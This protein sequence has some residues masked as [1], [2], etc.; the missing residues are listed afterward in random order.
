MYPKTSVVVNAAYFR[1]HL[2]GGA[3][4][5][6]LELMHHLR[7][8]EELQISVLA[9][10]QAVEAFRDTTGVDVISVNRTNYR[11]ANRLWIEQV[12]VPRALGLAMP[13]VVHTLGGMMPIRSS[14]WAN[15]FTCHDLQEVAL[16]SNFQR[17]VRMARRMN[18]RV[19][20]AQV[21]EIVASSQHTAQELQE[22]YAWPPTRVTVALLAG[23]MPSATGVPQAEQTNLGGQFFLY[24]AAHTAHKNHSFLLKAYAQLRLIRPD[25][26]KLVLTGMNADGVVD[27]T[28]EASEVGVGRD[29]LVLGRV[30]ISRLANLMRDATAVV[31]P[32][33]Y[34]GFGL[35]TLEAMSLGTPV[36]TSPEGSLAEVVGAGALVVPTTSVDYWVDAMQRIWLDDGLRNRLMIAGP[37]RAREFSWTRTARKT[38]EAYTKALQFKRAS[39]VSTND[40]RAH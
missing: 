5:Y 21:D 30:E 15:V 9:S 19:N 14:P 18:M 24:P 4:T 17:R 32:S 7:M 20:L 2:G 35:P 27:L 8:I 11:Q 22:Y 28:R 26:P 23:D 1:S 33:T 34:E 16:P 13:D 36:L 29:V 37:A 25:A 31:F 6:V 10:G 39:S 40:R 3:H 12:A 38:A